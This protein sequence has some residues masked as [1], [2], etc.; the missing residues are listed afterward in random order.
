MQA[1]SLSRAGN[2]MSMVVLVSLWPMAALA[3]CGVTTGFVAIPSDSVLPLQVCVGESDFCWLSC[4][5]V[6]QYKIQT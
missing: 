1:A 6:N 3:H 5:F 2:G 4:P